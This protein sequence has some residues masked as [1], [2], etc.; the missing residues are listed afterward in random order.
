MQVELRIL[1]E[2]LMFYHSIEADGDQILVEKR[3]ALKQLV[4]TVLF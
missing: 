1:T 2:D 4:N 3:S